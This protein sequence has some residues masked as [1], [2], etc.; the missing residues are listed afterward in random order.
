MPTMSPAQRMSEGRIRPDVPTLPQERGD[1]L[2]T[3]AAAGPHGEDDPTAQGSRLP[4]GS[5]PRSPRRAHLPNAPGGTSRRPQRHLAPKRGRRSPGLPR[6]PSPRTRPS[7]MPR[8]SSCRL[9]LVTT[10]FDRLK[11]WLRSKCSRRR[12]VPTDV[13]AHQGGVS[14][15]RG[16]G[17]LRGLPPRIKT[18]HA[19]R[20]FVPTRIESMLYSLHHLL[21]A[22]SVASG[23]KWFAATDVPHLLCS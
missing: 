7:T 6:C 1:R 4:H 5:A 12:C 8:P 13:G 11:G 2:A 21:E 14:P 3:H 17:H 16:K 18:G 9:R 22:L 19:S 10:S 23:F 20:I 15:S